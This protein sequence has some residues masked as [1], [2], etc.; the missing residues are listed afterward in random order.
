M[1]SPTRTPPAVKRAFVP[2]PTGQAPRA[3]RKAK[4]AQPRPER[5]E[6]RHG[7][8]LRLLSIYLTV[9][10]ACIAVAILMLP[11]EIQTRF[12]GKVLPGRD[13]AALLSILS[14]LKAAWNPADHQKVLDRAAAK[15]ESLELALH[16]LLAQPAH[17]FIGQA[18]ELAGELHLPSTREDLEKLAHRQELQVPALFALDRFEPLPQ[19]QLEELA[20]NKRAEVR[21][22]AVQIAGRHTPPATELIL[23]AL[24]DRDAT[25]RTAALAALPEQLPAESADALLALA[26]DGD[27][28]LAAIGLGA[29]AH[30]PVTPPIEEGVAAATR[31]PETDLAILAMRVLG[32]KATPLAAETQDR[33]WHVIDDGKQPLLAAAFLA[34][35]R[36]HSFDVADV[37]SRATATSDAVRY[38]TAR[39]LLT[40][41]D[42]TGIDVLLDLATT[43]AE[44]TEREAKVVRFATLTLLGSLAK[45]PASAPLDDLRQ[46]F[47]ANPVTGPL[48]LPAPQFERNDP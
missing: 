16:W 33:L 6:R 15:P 42:S 41:G 36:T 48:H 46:W 7:R 29:L 40:A 18:I 1:N 25:V 30:L 28:Q 35:E 32:Q 9:A 21:V 37:R 43:H 24:R 23:E 10:M 5:R 38:F 4:T 14:D 45:M 17:R 3:P 31:R 44:A 39:L 27:A 26:G 19:D 12:R 11:A 13:R 47:A 20:D 2:E 22:A 34:L 8:G